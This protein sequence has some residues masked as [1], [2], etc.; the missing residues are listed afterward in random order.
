MIKVIKLI[1]YTIA[2]ALGGALVPMMFLVSE[3]STYR[4]LDTW[5]YILISISALV[6]A[7]VCGKMYYQLL[8]DQSNTNNENT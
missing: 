7:I 2:G 6:G 4:L 3:S 8:F 5:G 1:F